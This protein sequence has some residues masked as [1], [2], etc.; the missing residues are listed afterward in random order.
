MNKT[1][2]NGA[3]S[4]SGSLDKLEF[5][6]VEMFALRNFD[7]V[8]NQLTIVDVVDLIDINAVRPVT[9]TFVLTQTHTE[10]SK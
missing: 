9:Y 2:R 1:K 4:I 6:H 10:L 7:E 8:N 5:I 3:Y